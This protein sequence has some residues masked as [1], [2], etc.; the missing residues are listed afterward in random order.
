MNR[1][2]FLVCV[3]AATATTYA[4]EGSQS[5]AENAS[6]PKQNEVVLTKLS[7]PVYPQLAK[8]ARVAGDVELKLRIRSDGAVESADAIS[9]PAML[10]EAALASSRQSK[11]ECR[12]CS[13]DAG[14]YRLT[15]SFQLVPT[16]YGADC[17]ITSNPAYPQVVQ[18]QKRVT[19]ID[20]A[21]GFCDLGATITKVRSV[22]C[23]YLWKCGHR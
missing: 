19:V 4:V 6:I 20:R 23:L 10:R 18:S 3:L 8:Q 5:P 22:K 7:N 21:T 17:Q 11:F 16:E 14:S 12:N 13:D 15:Y 2:I 9:G 1:F